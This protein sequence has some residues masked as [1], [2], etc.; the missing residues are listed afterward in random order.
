MKRIALFVVLSLGVIIA[1]HAQ[2]TKSVELVSKQ[3]M[4]KTIEGVNSTNIL[5][6]FMAFHKTWPTVVGNRVV[7]LS[8][9]PNMRGEDTELQLIDNANGFL[10]YSEDDPDTDLSEAVQAC[11][12]RRTDG[13]RLL[14]INLDFLESEK[15]QAFC[16]YDY[17]PQTKQLKPEKSLATLFKPSFPTKRFI[18]ELPRK[19]KTM[20]IQEYFG[21]IMTHYTYDWDGMKPVLKKTEIDRMDYLEGSYR[22]R[23]TVQVAHPFSQFTMVD[24]NKDGHA[25]I[26]L[27]SDDNKYQMVCELWPTTNVLGR[28]GSEVIKQLQQS[29]EKRTWHKLN[30]E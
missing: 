8:K 23:H 5:D 19:G 29:T 10:C 6:L 3:W 22:S 2:T 17:D 21:A 27:R 9:R 25:D 14:A 4:N 12:W 13:H 24:V 11:V 16:F 26:W 7:R 15:A 28:E 30:I 18:V 1:L 20:I